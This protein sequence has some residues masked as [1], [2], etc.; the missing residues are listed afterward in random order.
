MTKAAKIPNDLTLAR[1]EEIV[2]KKAQH[3]VIDVRS[4]ADPDRL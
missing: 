3:V 2:T 1:G 4:M